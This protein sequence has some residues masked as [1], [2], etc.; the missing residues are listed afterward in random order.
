MTTLRKGES[1]AVPAG[2]IHRFVN[3]SGAP[4]EALEVY[5]PEVL[6]VDIVRHSTGGIL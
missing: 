4:V 6:G 5:Y 3:K 1:M 2:R